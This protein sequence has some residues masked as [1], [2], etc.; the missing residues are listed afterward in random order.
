MRREVRSLALLSLCALLALIMAGCGGSN[1]QLIYQNVSERTTWNADGTRLAFTSLGGNAMYYVYSVLSN[2]A[3][4]TLLTLPDNDLDLNDEGGKMP[5]W[6]PNGADIAIVS[7]RTGTQSLYLIDPVQGD[8]VRIERVTDEAA[9]GADAQP[10]WL[11]DSSR[12]VYISTKGAAGDWDLCWINRDGTV[13]AGGLKITNTPGVNEQWPSVSPDG[14]FIAF[15]NGLGQR[16]ANTDIWVL[17]IGTG[18]LTQLTDSPFR[19]EAPSWSPDGATI[20]FHSDRGGD[21]D[22]WAMNAD[23]TN[24]R[25]LTHDARSDGFPVWNNA[26][27]RFAFTRDREL[28]TAAADG[29]DPKQLTRRY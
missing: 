1:D 5:A 10:T 21:F 16:G 8:R 14:Q 17:N 24:Q 19:D 3:G 29:S 12:I 20:L 6:S 23:G 22:I 2:G 28:W 13:P 15:Q 18:A 26:G 27:T 4:Q 11:P 7:R 9:E 25:S